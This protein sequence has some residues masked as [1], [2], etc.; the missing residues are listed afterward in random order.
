M[1]TLKTEGAGIDKTRRIGGEIH[2]ALRAMHHKCVNRLPEQ[3]GMQPMKVQ[4]FLWFSGV[5]SPA[6]YK[7]GCIFRLR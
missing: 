6:G 4:Y 2:A 1:E 7:R 5:D 3:S